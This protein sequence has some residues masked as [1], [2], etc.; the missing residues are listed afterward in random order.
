MTYPGTLATTTATLA[1]ALLACHDNAKA[2]D[3][4]PTKPVIV[5][6]EIPVDPYAQPPGGASS[7]ILTINR[8]PRR[9]PASNERPGT[10]APTEAPAARRTEN[11]YEI[12][13]PTGSPVPTPTIH[14]GKLL[15]SGG[16]NSK[17]IYAY[18]AATGR[19]LWGQTLS[20]DGPSASV[21]EGNTC[22]FNSESCTTFALD[23]RTGK[24]TWAWWL[25]DPQTSSPALAG[26]RVFA[27]YPAQSQIPTGAT[28]V[29]AAFDLATGKPLWRR[30][31]DG[32][33]MS[34][35]VAVDGFVYL[36]TFAG[37]VMKLDQVTGD[38]RYAIAM[39][40]TSAPVVI[41][42]HDRESL[43][44]TRRVEERPDETKEAIVRADLGDTRLTFRAHAKMA[45]YLDS[46]IQDGT[47]LAK[48]GKIDD[49]ENGFG[50]T[51]G[52][53]NA[54]AA[55]GMVGVA[56][57]STM[58]RFQGSRVLVAGDL[59][60]STMGDE[61]VA[62]D[63]TTGE[64]R[65]RHPLTGD[66]R[67]AGGHLGTAPLLAGKDIVVATVSGDVV[68]LDAKTGKLAATYH[69]GAPL[70]S[71]PVVEG[72]WIYVGS[73]DGRLIAIDTHDPRLTGWPTWGGD[74]G[75]T[76]VRAL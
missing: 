19:P 44:I 48:I 39:R 62:V 45:P 50:S 57:V 74:N 8:D 14:H 12:R 13:F 9:A 15:V 72:G 56:S 24:L 49:G 31:L 71:Q 58:Q 3:V 46:R 61:V 1:L 69:T 28:H 65:W 52:A 17:Q 10:G 35:P 21:C 36:T 34:S 55:T 16:F 70:R 73:E 41:R 68:R 64:T 5:L 47:Q 63:S 2:P 75:R 53:A 59:V 4:D 76:A 42:D 38:I 67:T 29:I 43:H 37:T 40:A 66:T 20:D 54:G 26:G 60:V 33:V 32:D 6:P 27:S 22:V 7:P 30:W 18:Q 23:I 11:G 51:P 25:G